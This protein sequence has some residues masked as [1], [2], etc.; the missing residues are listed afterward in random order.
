[1]RV[2]P[3]SPDVAAADRQLPMGHRP[4]GDPANE[5]ESA[6]EKDGKVM[7]ADAHVRRLPRFPDLGSVGPE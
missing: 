1:M 5:H 3:S 7:E 6:S 4:F 2:T